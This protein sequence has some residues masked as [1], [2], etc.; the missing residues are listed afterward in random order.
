MVRYLL[1]ALALGAT[2]PPYV[3]AEDYSQSWRWSHLGVA[4]GLPS[5]AALVVRESSDGTLW[6]GTSSGVFWF[7]GYRFNRPGGAGAVNQAVKNLVVLG[8]GDMAY[9]IDGV[10]HMGNR[11]RIAVVSLPFSVLA[12]PVRLAGFR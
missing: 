7:D 2:L 6:V 1:I 11:E 5:G 8:D 12:T 9:T 10:L 3:Q 4:E